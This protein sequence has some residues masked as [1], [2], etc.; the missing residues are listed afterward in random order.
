[1]PPGRPPR[2]SLASTPDDGPVCTSQIPLFTTDN[3]PLADRLNFAD[4]PRPFKN[5]YFTSKLAQRTASSTTTIVRKN[6]KQILTLERERLSGGDGF[7]TAS[8]TQQKLRGLPIDPAGKKKATG[9]GVQKKARGNIANL[10][11]GRLSNLTGGGGGGSGTATPTTVAHDGDESMVDSR[12][13]T[14]VDDEDDSPGQGNGLLGDGFDDISPKGEI[15]TCKQG[16]WE[17]CN[18]V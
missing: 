14:P 8:Q 5:P 3:Q 7:L 12:R 2:K 13:T 11:K 10:K 17:A 9:T 18:Q 16:L 6:V 4:V 1:M 15:L